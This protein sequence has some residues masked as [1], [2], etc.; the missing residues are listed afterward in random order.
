MYLGWLIIRNCVIVIINKFFIS[1]KHNTM[2]C[3]HQILRIK[4]NVKRECKCEFSILTKLPNI[5]YTIHS[6]ANSIPQAS[7]V[8]GNVLW[9]GG[10]TP[11]CL[12][13]MI[14]PP[15][16]RRKGGPGTLS[17]N[18]LVNSS[19]PKQFL[20]YFWESKLYK[21]LKLKVKICI[22]LC[23]FTHI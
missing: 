4:L 16:L 3:N 21:C 18:N 22:I 23:C 11:G 20:G 14:S 17:W 10:S 2:H 15:H 6:I 8:A 19:S 12:G 7:G 5:H 1:Y 9:V 13:G